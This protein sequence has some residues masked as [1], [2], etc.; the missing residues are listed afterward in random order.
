MQR[1]HVPTALIFYLQRELKTYLMFISYWSGVNHVKKDTE[2]TTIDEFLE[3]IKNGYWKDQ[4]SLIRS[5]NDTERKKL[6]KKTLPAVTIGGTFYERSE[7]KLEKHSG[8]ICID[9][10]NYSDRTR[11][12]QDEY[13]YASFISTGGNGIAVICKCDPLKH[14]ESYNFLAEHYF[15]SFG[16]TVDPA[17]KNVASARFVSFDENLFLNSKSKKLKTKTEKKKLPPN[18]SI[19]I[20]KG[21]IG[22]LVNKVNISVVDN[23][24]DYLNLSFALA[25][26]F[27]EDG[28][29]YFH[30]ISSLSEKYNSEQAEKQYDIALKRNNFGITV[31]T[32]YYYLKQAGVDL[33]Q[34]NSDKAISKVKLN[35]RMNTPIIEAVKELAIER[36]IAESEAQEIVNEV[37][38]RNDL[39]I[40]HESSAENIIINVTNYVIKKYSIKYN[41]ITRKN[42]LNGKPMTDK[43]SNTL[44][45]DCRMTFD[46]T[47]ITF[48]L[49]NR[50]IESKAVTDYNPFLLYI[51]NNKHKISGGNIDLICQTIESETHIKNRFIRKW[52]IGI[53]ACVYGHPVRYVLA[54][55]GGQNTGKTEWF[56]RLLPASLQAYYGESNLD[57]GKDDELLMCEKLIVVDDEMGGKSKQDEKRFKELTSKNYFSLRA[58]YGRH[59]QDYKRLAILAGTSNDPQLINDSTGNTRILPINVKSINHDLYNSIDKDE[60]FMELVRAYE[61]GEAYQLEETEFQILNEV[62]REFENI[63]FE[64]ELINKFFKLVVDQGEFLTATEIKDIIEINTKQRIMSMKKFGSELRNL[65]GTPKHRDKAQKYWVQRRKFNPEIL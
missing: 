1:V 33:S 46:D 29:G 35:K 4:V 14:K 54:L 28:R 44:F 42:E 39:D 12:D 34:Y 41:V 36:G 38:S 40:R 37:Y 56:R 62:S 58:S 16:I 59:N 55:T 61:S 48:D 13:T 65:F 8:F 24:S 3:R 43:D 2:R 30:K 21:D 20:P 63:A 26:G 7:S 57:R 49:V 32:F 17:P 50:I 52:L 64:R 25:T 60:L 19:L 27:S 18:L 47:A 9:V 15:E 45:L 6:H 23:Y 22:E 53:I 11:I 10:D 31:G 51:E 5:E